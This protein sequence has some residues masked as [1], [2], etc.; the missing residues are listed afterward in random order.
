[1]RPVSNEGKKK[2]KIM[3]SGRFTLLL[4]GVIATCAC[5]SSSGGGSRTFNA[6]G[7]STAN[8]PPGAV[9]ASLT[10]RDARG[11]A[12]TTYATGETITLVLQIAN[13]TSSDASFVVNNGC[14]LV[15]HIIEDK[16]AAQASP[17]FN[18]LNGLICT[19]AIVTHTVQAGQTM[20][21]T[22]DWRQVDNRGSQVRLGNYLFE[23][24]LRDNGNFPHPP[25]LDLAIGSNKIRVTGT[26]VNNGFAPSRAL[27]SVGQVRVDIAQ[28]T[29]QTALQT[30]DAIA[31]I[32]DADPDL[33]A[34]VVDL[35]SDTA[36]VTVT[37]TP[38]SPSPYF[39]VVFDV[40]AND[41]VQRVSIP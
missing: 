28:S 40:S 27:A 23:G 14:G 10:A 38:G 41:P 11:A 15:D 9:T 21:F 4:L 16:F 6:S 12:R 37:Q 36:E 17:L 8:A 30:A 34:A 25:R 26:A 24:A 18:R 1:L 39:P 22:F 33:T 19:Q 32:I 31:T 20:E 5:G 2:R 7:V 13:T 35:G 29:R 3:K